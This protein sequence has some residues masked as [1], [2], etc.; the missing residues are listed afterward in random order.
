MAFKMKGFPMQQGT[1]GFKKAAAEAAFRKET[2]EGNVAREGGNRP[3]DKPA[4]TRSLKDMPFGSAERI[5]EYKR[6]NWAMD[7]TTHPEKAEEG[8]ATKTVKPADKPAS[9]GKA[10]KTVKP[11]DKPKA[12]VKAA[13]AN[14]KAEKAKKRDAAKSKREER[15]MGRKGQRQENR[16][17]RKAN[18]RKAET[19]SV[20]P[21]SAADTK[22]K[23]TK[24]VK[25]A[26]KKVDPKTMQAGEVTTKGGKT[27]VKYTK[28]SDAD[29]PGAGGTKKKDYA[30]PASETKAGKAAAE[31]K[32]LAEKRAGQTKRQAVRAAKKSADYDTSD[33]Q[34][35]KNI[36]DE[37][38]AMSGEAYGTSK[39]DLRKARRGAKKR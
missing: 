19:L 23:M 2:L 10:T 31:R 26:D 38:A 27:T 11:A 29:A 6:R 36:R 14:L 20:K 37:A 28:K 32:A 34:E 9:E 35:R 3:E 25:D 8:K 21:G 33:R 7:K 30:T 4:K 12:G 22:G 15:R 18:K 13:K 1:S 17:N 24:T 5:A 16:D 39:R